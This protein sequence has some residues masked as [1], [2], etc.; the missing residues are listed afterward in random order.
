MIEKIF[1]GSKARLRIVKTI[2]ENPGINIRQLIR[3]AK[4]S[5]NLAVKYV[6]I[7]AE[8]GV[9]KEN[10]I[11]GKIKA[12]V[13]EVEANLNS[14][15]G[16]TLFMLV[17]TEKKREF[18]K[19]YNNF[20]PIVSQIGDLLKKG[21]ARF[22]LIHGSFARFSAD[23]NSDVDILIAGKLNKREKAELS[24]TLVTLEREYSVEIETL[25]NFVKNTKNPFHQ[26]ILKDHVVIWNESG[27]I[28]TLAGL[29]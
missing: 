28:E 23:K 5:P 26:T 22:C 7:L 20:V 21:N 14:D 4:V 17:E 13:K 19:K 11:G 1:P 6:N 10:V 8:Y 18:L 3:K 16:K 2:Y 24:E 29:E 25:E 27:F 15:L 12:H 9:V